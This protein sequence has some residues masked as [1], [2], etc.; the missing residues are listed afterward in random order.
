MAASA[1]TKLHGVA[2]P[3]VEDVIGY[4]PPSAKER[5]VWVMRLLWA[6]RFF[7]LRAGIAG[8]LLAGI[9]AFLIPKQFRSTTRLM[10]PD[11]Q[12]SSGGAMLSALTLRA[13]VP[14]MAANLLG[15]KTSGALFVGVLQSRTVADRIIGQFDLRKVYRVQ[16]WEDARKTLAD[17]T[18]I[19]EERKSGI[20]SVT[21]TD[22]DP[23][24]AAAI[25]QAYVAILDNLVSELNTSSAHRERVFLEDRL[26]VVKQDLEAA[27]KD[28]SLFASKN[29]AIDLK[30]QGK[31][32]VEAAATLQGQ[33][34]A[35]RSEYEGLKQIYTNNNVRV[36]SLAA[37]VDELQRQLEKLGGKSEAEPELYPSIRKIPLLG[38]AYADL[39]RRCKIQETVL[40]TLTQ[41][42][43]LAKVE[44]AK[45]VP[46]VKILD[47][48]N[49]PERKSFPPRLLIIFLGG[50]TGSLVGACI[51]LGTLAWTMVD[52]RDPVKIFAHE[53]SE[54]V[55]LPL[56][57][58]K[59]GEVIRT[60]IR[61]FSTIHNRD[62]RRSTVVETEE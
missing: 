12:T 40:E 21:V 36:R 27:E 53:I 15:M 46:T 2:A 37:R 28:M 45:E 57:R 24:R 5:T 44:E 9:I 1:D 11:S 6:R 35:A 3:T 25:A 34:I 7:L 58:R 29:T 4:A 48:A 62:K 59:S 18:D 60:K 52:P 47:P 39:Y 19:A 43:E 41:Q 14:G 10:P 55:K 31:A 32:M 23:N 49:I 42:Y 26:Q 51:L 16:T 61:Y 38:V 17:K 20:I 33:L 22:H 13:G 30:E 50:L 56:W 8:L 54:A